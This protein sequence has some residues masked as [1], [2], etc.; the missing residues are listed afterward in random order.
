MWVFALGLAN[1]QN[2]QKMY[3]K[4]AKLITVHNLI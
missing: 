2:I 4:I 1:D 3:E